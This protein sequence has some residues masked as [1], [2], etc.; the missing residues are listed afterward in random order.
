ME[1]PAQRFRATSLRVAAALAL[2]G[3]ALWILQSVA[4]RE[5]TVYLRDSAVHA[6]A[7]NAT[8]QTPYRWDFHD[9]QDIVAGRVFGATEFSFE[10][11]S[12]QVR[13]NGNPFEIGLPLSYPVD[14]RHFP[15]LHIALSGVPMKLRVVVREELNAAE[16]V[17]GSVDPHDGENVLDLSTAAWDT[18]PPRIAAMLRLRFDLPSAQTMSI[19]AATLERAPDAQRIDL[20][21]PPQMHLAQTADLPAVREHID[22]GTTPLLRLPQTGSVEQQLLQFKSIR[23]TSPAAIVIP[24][25]ADTVFLRAKKEAVLA[26]DQAL[27][28]TFVQWLLTCL[29]TLILAGARWRPPPNA[30]VRAA[31]EIALAL[32]VPLWLIAGGNFTGRVDGAQMVLIGATALYALTLGWPRTWRWNGSAH[33]W[34]LAGTVIALAAVVGLALHAPHSALRPISGGHILRYLGWALMQ[35]YL[36]CVVCV[37]RW[38]IVTGGTTLAVYLSAFCFALL[39]TP[40]A[41]LMLATFIGGLC[42]CTLYLRERALLPLAGSHA[43]SAT[44]LLA[45]LPPDI[46]FSA[47]VSARFFQ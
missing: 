20:E 41:S 12:L 28:G 13:S 2:L 8:G 42:W 38:R 22:P 14:L 7:L 15:Y 29:F 26:R 44:L 6:L 19:R 21:H 36:I 37:E 35:Q 45:L 25:D 11:A 33:A 4:Q 9:A 5:L 43:A 30:R 39:H 27:P 23:T 1:P 46:L 3:A 34:L 18:A 17:S 16:S 31:L 10:D 24:D 47:E 32:A 40:N